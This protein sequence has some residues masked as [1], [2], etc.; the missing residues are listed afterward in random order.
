MFA[1]LQFMH[2]QRKEKL[3]Y[4]RLSFYHTITAIKESADNYYLNYLVDVEAKFI[5]HWSMRI[6]FIL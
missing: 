1:I 6:A 4:S 5:S 2:L 3:S